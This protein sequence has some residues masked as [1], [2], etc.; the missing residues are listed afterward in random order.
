MTGTKVWALRGLLLAMPVLAYLPL[1]S[2]DFID[3]DDEPFLTTNAQVIGGLTPAG[4]EWAWTYHSPYWMPITWLSF[5]FDALFPSTFQSSS[6]SGLNPLVF[7][8][9]NLFWH[10]CNIQ[11]LFALFLRLTGMPWRSFSVAAL[12]AVH[13]MHV[14]SV[15]WAIERKDVLMC[16]F[17]LLSLHAYVRYVEKRSWMAYAGMLLAYQASLMCKPMLLTLP[18]LLFLLDFWPLC[19]FRLPVISSNRKFEVKEQQVPLGA[20]FLEKLPVF[21][22]AIVMAGVTMATRPGNPMPDLGLFDRAMNAFSGYAGY[23]SKTFYPDRLA[24]F[25]PHARHDWSPSLTYVGMGLVFICTAVA[26]WQANRWRWLPVGWLWFVGTLV[27]VIGLT[28][29]GYQGWANRF[30]Y[31]PH[32][33]LFVVIVWGSAEIAKRLRIPSSIWGGVWAIVL[34]SLMM[35]TWIQVGYWRTGIELWEHAL[36]VTE[37]NDRA[38]QHLAILY[39]RE[40]RVEEA[41]YHLHEEYRI[42]RERIHRAPR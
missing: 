42:Q 18:V 20:L 12:F 5:Q 39:R 34:G 15:A 41:D 2:N 6:Q 9:E 4:V 8:G 16:F 29:G 23:L 3:D 37:D 26:L 22:V 36:A 11:L 35:L 10:V 7:H 24:V 33:G 30:S 13:P 32:I 31:W 25:Y 38:H 19:R 21:A 28:Q 27:P 17:G 1:W 14:E 40:G